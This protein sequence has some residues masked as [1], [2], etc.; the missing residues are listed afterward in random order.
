MICDHRHG[1]RLHSNQTLSLVKTNY[2]IGMWLEQIQFENIFTVSWM[3]TFYIFR[4]HHNVG[5]Y[6]TVIL[7]R[8]FV[9]TS[10][11]NSNIII[12]FYRTQSLIT[13]K[14]RTEPM[15]T[16]HLFKNDALNSDYCT[17]YCAGSTVTNHLSNHGIPACLKRSQMLKDGKTTGTDK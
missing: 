15:V 11:L 3:S 10:T 7:F 6:I 12:G 8:Q 2:Y 17:D 16:D 13:V 9:T 5:N 14:S 1:T 4:V